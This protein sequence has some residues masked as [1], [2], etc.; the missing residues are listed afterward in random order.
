[1]RGQCPMRERER[2]RKDKDRRTEGGRREREKKKKRK[3]KKEEQER[4]RK[5]GGKTRREGK[6]GKGGKS[7]SVGVWLC[8]FF[9]LKRRASLFIIMHR[10]PA[11]MSPHVPLMTRNDPKCPWA[12]V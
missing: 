9:I 8:F 3:E 1:M 5:E 7:L 10:D 12:A 2:Q 6:R 4:E 11:L